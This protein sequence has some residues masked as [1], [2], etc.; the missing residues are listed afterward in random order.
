M[1]PER[2][3]GASQGQVIVEGNEATPTQAK[4]PA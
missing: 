4:A 2:V 3:Q 1:K